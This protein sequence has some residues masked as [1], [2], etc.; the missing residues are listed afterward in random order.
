MNIKYLTH[1]QGIEDL[2]KLLYEK[3]LTLI[4]GSGFT[5]GCKSSYGQVPDG[6][7]ATILMKEEII[8]AKGI[9]E[10]NA[11]FNK[12]AT[13]FY[14][15]V[16]EERRIKFFRD[17]FTYVQLEN[18]KVNFLNL[19]WDY[20]FTINVDD[21]IE[22]ATQYTPILPYLNA[23]VDNNLETKLLYKLHGDAH[24]EIHYEQDESIIFSPSQYLNSLDS[25]SNKSMKDAI[26]SEFKQKNLLFIGCSLSNEID[27]K[28]IYNKARSDI[29]PNSNRILLRTTRL[30]EEEELDME[31]YGI[32][33]VI[34]T[35][36]Y[37]LFYREFVIDYNKKVSSEEETYPYINP[38][39]EK[40]TTKEESLINLANSNI[41]NMKKNTFLLSNLFIFRKV[42]KRIE[43]E[44]EKF[45]C[46]VIQGR[47]FSGKTA[48]LPFL[49][50][51]FTNYTIYMFP[52]LLAAEEETI[53]KL[54]K[55]NHKSLLIFD[56]N[57]LSGDAYHA[58]AHFKP[59][60]NDNIKIVVM[61]NSHDNNMV[62]NQQTSLIR[63]PNSFI[64]EELTGFNKV[65]DSHGLI[66]RKV[67]STNID[68]LREI[69]NKQKV[70]IN[71]LKNLPTS[72]TEYDSM[73]LVL[74]AARDKVF[75]HEIH[76]LDIPFKCARDLVSRMVGVVESVPVTRHE[77]GSHSSEK[78]VHNS[79]Y[80]LLE[81]LGKLEES[82]IVSTVVNIVSK[83]SR[84]PSTKRA[85]IEVMLYDTLNQLFYNQTNTGNLIEKIY[86]NLEDSLSSDL[87]YWLQRAK[88]IYR[89]TF[90]SDSKEK[91]LTAYKFAK[92][93]YEDGNDRLQS[94]ASLSLS[95]ICC[96][97]AEQEQGNNREEFEREAIEYAVIA[98][99]SNQYVNTKVYLPREKLNYQSTS[100]KAYLLKICEK[101]TNDS[102][103]F[104]FMFDLAN[105]K[106]RLNEVDY[107]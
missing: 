67:K 86:E 44:L 70:T 40:C 33:T 72:F 83:L 15:F 26:Y 5:R 43:D 105:V 49:C 66:Q 39:L 73:L 57:A 19:G 71:R 53:R 74:L 78:L 41:F 35:T 47:R 34:I 16:P 77:R 30:S 97:L 75:Y 28:H 62:S 96:Q 9:I 51:R 3:K 61:V 52:S 102:S 103:D 87:D 81:I 7:E 59:E 100:H 22:R 42:I 85:S 31:E 6:N 24:Y 106:N 38:K 18:D 20:L 60:Y 45:S 95:V 13:R 65:A 107:F 2:T 104:K 12:T 10:E 27:F 54:L 82:E 37:N 89:N 55:N 25:D 23:R 8:K 32:N 4:L 11:D 91:L 58:V 76:V 92:K 93:S 68:Y 79:K 56:S 69:E 101:Y 17:Y 14:K 29:P 80:L 64:K 1:E 99:N 50:E 84:N 88:S 98:F 90:Q 94:K 63:I 46:V 36:D 21:A 48:I